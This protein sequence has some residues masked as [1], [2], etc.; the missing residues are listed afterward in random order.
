M[1]SGGSMKAR[2]ARV[3]KALACESCE[4]RAELVAYLREL[5]AL[6]AE[7]PKIAGTSAI[8]CEWCGVRV[9]FTYEVGDEELAHAL[10]RMDVLFWQGLICTPE[11]A[12]QRAVAFGDAAR[13]RF[14]RYGEHA[15]E[16]EAALEAHGR[17]LDAIKQPPMPYLCRV[18]GCRCA[19][20]KTLDEWRANIRARGY[21][22]AA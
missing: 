9:T 5:D 2:L 15:A 14:A 22:V 1:K 4:A 18:P 20:P 13:E 7:P 17:R 12:E 3:E 10:E 8:R 21:R 11:Y 19:Y 16:V 6:R